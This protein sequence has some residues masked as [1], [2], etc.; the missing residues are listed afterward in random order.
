MFNTPNRQLKHLGQTLPLSGLGTASTPRAT[1]PP[2]HRL[3]LGCS[4]R[5]LLPSARAC[6]RAVA[7]MGRCCACPLLSPPF[8]P[9]V[10]FRSLALQPLAMGLGES[11]GERLHGV[12]YPLQRHGG[13]NA[14]GRLCQILRRKKKNQTNPDGGFKPGP[15]LGSHAR[16]LRDPL[17]AEIAEMQLCTHAHGCLHFSPPR[18]HLRADYT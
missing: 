12:S 5:A 11:P 10:T 18:F 6:G 13:R 3:I 17:C 7:L 2:P 9:P 4:G 1:A 8:P 16:L 15:A 14:L